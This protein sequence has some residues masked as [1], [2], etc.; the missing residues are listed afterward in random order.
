MAYVMINKY[1]LFIFFFSCFFFTYF[2]SRGLP[3]A[4]DAKRRRVS[5]PII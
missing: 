5:K 4:I 3:Y 2:G 1:I